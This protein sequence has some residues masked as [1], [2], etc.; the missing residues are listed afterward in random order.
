MQIELLSC[1]VILPQLQIVRIASIAVFFR[2]NRLH[3]SQTGFI[4]TKV[5]QI[6]I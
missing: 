4:L 3:L 5:T 6:N 1:V 2:V